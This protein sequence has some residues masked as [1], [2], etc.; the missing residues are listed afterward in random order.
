MMNPI[1]EFLL[2]IVLGGVIGHWLGELIYYI[3]LD[4]RERRD[5]R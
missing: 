1:T 3:R 5:K 2:T 4:I